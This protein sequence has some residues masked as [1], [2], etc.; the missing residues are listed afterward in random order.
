MDQ[1]LHLRTAEKEYDASHEAVRLLIRFRF[2]FLCLPG[3]ELRQEAS[4]THA[5]PKAV[6]YTFS[7]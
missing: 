7:Q 4:D 2:F 3:V 5:L 1:W 6:A